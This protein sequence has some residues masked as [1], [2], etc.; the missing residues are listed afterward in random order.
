MSLTF[1]GG[2]LA[3]L[4]A[5][6]SGGDPRW[7]ALSPLESGARAVAL[8]VSGRDPRWVALSPL[9]SGAEPWRWAVGSHARRVALTIGVVVVDVIVNADAPD[10]GRRRTRSWS[11][12]LTLTPL[13]PDAASSTHDRLENLRERARPTLGRSLTAHGRNVPEMSAGSRRR[14]RQVS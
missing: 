5:Y 4:H 1:C 14:G 7:V 3:R 12:T 13:G 11:L 6:A 9:Q 2:S 8:Y 10:P